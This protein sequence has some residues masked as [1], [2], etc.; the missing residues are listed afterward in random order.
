MLLCALQRPIIDIHSRN[1]FGHR[2]SPSGQSSPVTRS[3]TAT[4]GPRSSINVRHSQAPSNPFPRNALE[5]RTYHGTQVHDRHKPTATYN[6]PPPPTSPS[7][8]DHVGNSSSSGPGSSKGASSS[9][10][11]T[12]FFNKLSSRFSRRLVF[13]DVTA[14]TRRASAVE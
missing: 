2:T 8:N 9:R 11:S 10:E 4:P 6:G 14:Q 1:C 13:C 5:R 3:S 7:M 12:G